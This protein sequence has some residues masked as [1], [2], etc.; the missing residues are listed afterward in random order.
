[1]M[2]AMIGDISVSSVLPA[3]YKGYSIR[4]MSISAL[5][6]PKSPVRTIFNV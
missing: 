5:G 2:I 1:M 3:F 4:K 6:N